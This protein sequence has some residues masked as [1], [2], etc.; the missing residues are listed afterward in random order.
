MRQ[1]V[2]VSRKAAFAEG[3]HKNL[4]VQFRAF[5]LFCLYFHLPCLPTNLDTLSLYVQFLKRSF[6]SMTSVKNYVNGAKVLHLTLGYTFPDPDYGFR[7]LLKG[8]ARLHPHEE[9]RALPITPG[10]LLSL[11][12]VMDMSSPL[13]ASLWCCFVSAFF[14]FARKSTMLPPTVAS[15]TRKKHL[16]RGD[17]F[18]SEG[19]LVVLIRWSKTLQLGERHLQVPLVEIPGSVLCPCR[20]F[21]HMVRLLTAE[22]VSPAFLHFVNG[23]LVSVCH[24]VFVGTLG[25]LLR[26]AGVD[27]RGFTGH[28][29]RRGGA[30]W[31]FQAGVPGELIQLHGD[32]RSDA[33]LKYLSVPMQQKMQV[34]HMMRRRILDA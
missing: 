25:K 10:I 20:A 14:L 13:H 2:R 9:K 26:L 16:T 33:Y 27:A 23:G 7:L 15:F 30:S 3:T 34:G 6:V 18:R 5:I 32:W 4:R 12:G 1:Q 22:D 28:S 8:L 19:A 21:D 31:A 17:F 29:F 24:R 11:F